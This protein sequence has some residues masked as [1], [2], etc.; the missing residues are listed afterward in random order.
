MTN[1]ILT[2]TQVVS[3]VLLIVCIL[4]QQRGGGLGGTFGG[5]SLEYSTRRGVE[6]WLLY[7]TIVLIIV[8][9]G[10]SLTRLVL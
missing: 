7:S 2:Y 8:F 6:K 10:V 4:L 1:T 5:S 3:A 9:V